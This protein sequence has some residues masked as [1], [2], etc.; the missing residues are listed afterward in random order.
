MTPTP[1]ITPRE[2]H[3]DRA[4]SKA[5]EDCYGFTHI[6]TE[7]ARA[8]HGIGREG[9]AVIGIEGAWG[10]GK[11]SLLNL[12]RIALDEQQEERTY[13]LNISPWLDGSDTPLV[14]SLL[15][16]VAGIIAREEES[17]LSATERANLKE[18][19]ALTG[20]ASTLMDYTRATA[21]RLAPLAQIAAVV[22]GIPDASGALK[23][24]SDS[25]WL[26]EKEKTTAEMRAVIAEKIA[27]LDLSFIVLLDDLDRLEPAQAVEVIRLVKSVADF[28]RFR[29]LL[30]YDKAV[31]SQ[32]I[33]Q[34]LG[35]DGS[36]Y[37][38]KIVQIAFALPRPEAFV[39]RRQFLEEAIRLYKSVNGCMPETS[40]QAALTSVADIYG[41]A[42]RTPREVRIA[43]N[44]LA[45]RY[46]GLRDYVYF[47]DLCFLQLLRT[48]NAGLYDWVETYL[49][50]RAV[51]ESGEGHISEEEQKVMTESLKTHLSPYFPG[52]AHTVDALSQWVPGIS[53]G[54][55][56]QA[57]HLFS[58][59][60]EQEKTMLTAG[61][62]LGS[63]AY[64]RYY[65]A[66]SAPQNV[67]QPA[68]FDHIFE[69]AGH[70]SKQHELA[71][72]LLGYIQRKNLSSRTWFEHILGRIEK[73][74]KI[75]R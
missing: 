6:A 13:V 30:C 31:L 38:Q 47:P 75:V 43:I 70:P 24:L 54:V 44:A 11:T 36:L 22:P 2:K 29:Y 61:K 27:A 9:S 40:M 3:A 65:F 71:E 50:E 59:D 16:P 57:I 42:L 19:N 33:S 18:K 12:L 72:L 62:R 56:D 46:A 73:T 32:A 25:D 10:T 7:L 64:W 48:T 55:T 15:L 35:V 20:T 34:G 14:A 5:E 69:V 74:E 52:E 51:V 26:K 37:L 45:F 4:V 60:S 21:R 39:L 67:L 41:A 28:P 53:A 68:V 58:F 49:S 23:A 66:F 1:E 63:Q 17:R 8:I